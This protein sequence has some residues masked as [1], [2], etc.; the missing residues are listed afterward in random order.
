MFELYAQAKSETPPLGPTKCGG[1][2]V[3]SVLSHAVMSLKLLMLA[4]C[5]LES[6]V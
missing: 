4:G 3:C 1:D 2:I 5:T 6:V